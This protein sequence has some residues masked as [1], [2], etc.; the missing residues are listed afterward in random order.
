MSALRALVVDVGDGRFAWVQAGRGWLLCPS[1]RT[2]APLVEAPGL[3]G[4][5]LGVTQ[6]AALVEIFG[7]P[8]EATT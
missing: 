4:R 6:T 7:S 1:S 2:W 8:T 3:G 5:V